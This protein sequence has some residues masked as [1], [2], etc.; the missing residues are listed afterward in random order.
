MLEHVDLLI[1]KKRHIVVSPTHKE[2]LEAIEKSPGIMMTDLREHL[3]MDRDQFYNITTDLSN[4]FIT[5]VSPVNIPGRGGRFCKI[6]LDE[7]LNFIQAAYAS[8]EK[9]TKDKRYRN[10]FLEPMTSHL[11]YIDDQKLLIQDMCWN[12]LQDMR[13][14][15]GGYNDTQ[16]EIAARLFISTRSVYISLQSLVKL[17]LADKV[18]YQYRLRDLDFDNIMRCRFYTMNC[19]KPIPAMK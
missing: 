2:V 11:Y 18:K 8:T 4:A 3:G 10:K 1:N 17:G 9:T 13:R 6:E 5:K 7:P 14:S 16:L 19:F 12:V 15:L